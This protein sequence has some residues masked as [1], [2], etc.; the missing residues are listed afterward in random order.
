[1]TAAPQA[2]QIVGVRQRQYFVE[3]LVPPAAGDDSSLVLMSCLATAP[4]VGCRH[5]VLR[6]VPILLDG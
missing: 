2:G 6:A 1:M 3:E 5:G 4:R